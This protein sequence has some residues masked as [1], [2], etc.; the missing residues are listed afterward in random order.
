MKLEKVNSI[1]LSL[2]EKIDEP[3]MTT[4]KLDGIIRSSISINLEGLD[5]EKTES[6]FRTMLKE[7]YHILCRSVNL[8]D[9]NYLGMW[10]KYD[11]EIIDNSISI[12]TLN[13]IK[14]F[15]DKEIDEIY[16][17]FLMSMPDL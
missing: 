7:M 17:F 1:K 9:V 6:T 4:S 11:K 3:N 13:D 5:I 12:Q 14:N 8:P 16:E 2:I 10:I 15:S